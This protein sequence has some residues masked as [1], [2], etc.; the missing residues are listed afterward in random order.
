ML[1][2]VVILFLLFYFDFLLLLAKKLAG[3]SISDMTYLVSRATL[4]L[5]QSIISCQKLLKLVDEYLEIASQSSVV[6]GIQHDLTYPIS[7]VHV[8][9]GSAETFS[10]ER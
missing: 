9:P 3:K 5:N 2:N 1:Y 6:F 8:S 7:G 4:N 10:W